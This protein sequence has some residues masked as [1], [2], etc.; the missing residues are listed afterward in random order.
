ML[1]RSSLQ[2]DF[3]ALEFKAADSGSS[4]RMAPASV[5]GRGHTGRTFVEL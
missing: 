2:S 3:L 4:P 1:R 5:T